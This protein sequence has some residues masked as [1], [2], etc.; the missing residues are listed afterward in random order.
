MVDV[1]RIEIEVGVKIIWFLFVFYGR[2]Y[3]LIYTS[4]YAWVLY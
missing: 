2:Y 1:G 3:G 4:E